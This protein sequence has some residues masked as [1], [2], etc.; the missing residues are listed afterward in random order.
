M[1]IIPSSQLLPNWFRK[2]FKLLWPHQNRNLFSSRTSDTARERKKNEISPRVVLQSHPC[3]CFICM[4]LGAILLVV[5]LTLLPVSSAPVDFGRERPRCQRCQGASMHDLSTPFKG[6]WDEKV[7]AVTTSVP[8]RFSSVPSPS[9]CWTHR[10]SFQLQ[11]YRFDL[12]TLPLLWF[13]P[14]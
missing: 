1:R 11:D 13:S 3:L 10:P 8:C 5:S 9:L 12:E 2:V 7:Q 4:L 6:V 14:S